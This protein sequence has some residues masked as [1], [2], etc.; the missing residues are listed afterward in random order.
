MLNDDQSSYL[1]IPQH[2]LLNSPK[3]E[4]P[5][6]YVYIGE[7]F[8]QVPIQNVKFNDIVSAIEEVLNEG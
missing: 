5:N 6:K 4:V 8:Y 2:I 1:A 7:M 3:K